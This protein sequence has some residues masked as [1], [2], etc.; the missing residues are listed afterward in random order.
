M[1]LWISE[2]KVKSGFKPITLYSN[3]ITIADWC[4]T[5]SNNNDALCS[6]KYYMD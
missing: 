6:L 3:Q 1:A 5:T 4:L 2:E